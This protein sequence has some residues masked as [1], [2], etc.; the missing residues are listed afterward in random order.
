VVLLVSR[1]KLLIGKYATVARAR[2]AA[3]LQHEIGTHLVT[4]YN[5]LMQPFQQLHAGLAGYEELQEGLAVLAEYLVGGLSERRM[6]VLA[7][8]VIAVESIAEGAD[9]AETFHILVKDHGFD[10]GI[11][12][13]I[14]MR[15]HRAGGFSKDVIYL[16]GLVRL[17]EYLADGGDH[18]ELLLGKVSFAQLEVIRE[19]RWRRILGAPRLRPRYL[20][21][22][23]SR[24]RMQRLRDGL[25]VSD[26]LDE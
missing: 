1:G 7:G 12:Y 19:L 3:T 10:P 18:S 15:A 14:T 26:L 24:E 16:R 22:P 13:S 21:Y 5:G 4:Y 23:G 17:L 25:S 6:R 8:R 9:F 20:D 2:V 11:A